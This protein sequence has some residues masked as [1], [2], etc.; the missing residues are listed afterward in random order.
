MKKLSLLLIPVLATVTAI[1]AFCAADMN[2]GKL[3]ESL[4]NCSYFKTSSFITEDGQKIKFNEKITGYV[5]G[6]CRYITESHY[7]NGTA[8]GK[9]CD[10]DESQ[11]YRLYQNKLKP[12]QYSNPELVKCESYN[13]VNDR[14]IKS[15]KN[16]TLAIPR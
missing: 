10:L 3:S 6:K 2:K 1:P 11:R 4:K 16:T 13:L 12:K 8:T 5:N 9:I 15:D 14:W 7:S